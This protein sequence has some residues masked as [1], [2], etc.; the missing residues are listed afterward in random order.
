MVAGQRRAC[1]T[2][3][4][5]GLAITV[6]LVIVALSYYQTIHGYPSGGGSYVVARDN[7][8]NLPGLVAAAALL[9]DYLLTAAVSLTAGVAAIASAFPELWPYRVELALGLL[10]VITLVNLRGMREAGT[11]DGRAGLPVPG[12]LP[13]DAASMA[14]VRLLIEAPPRWQRSAPPALQPLTLFLVLHTFSTGCTAL[15]GIEAISNGVPAF[16]P[17]QAQ[18]PAH[19]DRDGDPDGRA[20]RGQH[21][22]D[23]V[24]GRHRRPAGDHP[25]GAGAPAV[26]QRRRRTSCPAGHAAD[27]G[28]GGQHQLRRLSRAWRPSWRGTASCR[29]SSR[30]LGDRL[31]FANGILSWAADRPR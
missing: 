21:R 16:Q 8:G 4:P 30:S 5:I 3:W 7:L 11:A 14:S 17:P 13:A 6:L 24:P 25:L 23:A 28:G 29:A 9:I 10:L 12:R 31:V 15:T 27:P 26:R 18:T 1:R 19:A 20:V 22:A 2:A